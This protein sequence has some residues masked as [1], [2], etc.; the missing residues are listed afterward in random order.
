MPRLL[1]ADDS[2]T[3]QRVI[4]LTFADE[5]VEVV[6]VGDG[7]QAIDRLGR[8]KFDIVLADIGMPGK[9]GFAVAAHVQAQPDLAGLP[10]VLLTGAFDMVDQVRVTEVNAAGVL[11]KPFEPHMV[12]A[13]V[14]ELLGGAPAAAPERGPDP[15][16][17]AE[18]GSTEDY[19]DRLDKAF[20]SLTPT[21]EP[22][23]A[24]ARPEPQAPPAVPAAAAPPEVPATMEPPPVA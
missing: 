2:V 4:E 16:A 12:I 13:K 10:V 14:R 6:S 11:A 22:R 5:G 9:D 24:P 7:Q 3:I 21:L 17:P 8:E 23:R 1:L 18:A 19:F 20:A 15:P